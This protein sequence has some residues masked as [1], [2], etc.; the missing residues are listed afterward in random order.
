MGF[1]TLNRFLL[2]ILGVIAIFGCA[3][4][5]GIYH[6]VQPGENLYRISSAYGM[7]SQE[8]AEINGIEDPTSISIGT[9]V[10]VPGASVQRKVKLADGSFSNPPSSSSIKKITSETNRPQNNFQRAIR[11]PRR[12]VDHPPPSVLSFKTD[13]IWPTNGVLS[14]RFGPR[15]GNFHDG[16]DISARKGT[17][18]RAAASGRVIYSDKKMKGYGKLIIIKH[19]GPYSTVYAHNSVNYVKR[20]DFVR[21]G[22]IIGRVG[23]TGRA[24]GPH[25][26]FEV[27]KQRK[28]VNPLYYLPKK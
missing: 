26:H 21:K 11:S 19:N 6:E 24:T 16:L 13:F 22:E 2:A 5:Y 27:R 7:N 1:K 8:L 14:S 15:S 12:P 23:D 20:N 9:R 3:R 4:H 17:P 25:L 10:F 28:A 18:I